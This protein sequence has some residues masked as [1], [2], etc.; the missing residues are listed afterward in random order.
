MEKTRG[1]DEDLAKSM[2]GLES[3]LGMVRG[4]AGEWSTY[5]AEFCLE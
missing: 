3:A 2:N 4:A 1:P 5:L